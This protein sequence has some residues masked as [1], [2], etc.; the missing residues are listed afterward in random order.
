MKTNAQIILQVISISFLLLL[1]C[2]CCFAGSAD[3]LTT[4]GEWAVST[5]NPMLGMS[6]KARLVVSE[7]ADNSGSRMAVTYVELQNPNNAINVL[8][9]Y[10]NGSL[11]ELS[12]ELLDSR[13]KAV[14]SQMSGPYNG[15][16]PEPCW[17]ALPID[18]TVRFHPSFYR[19]PAASKGEL[20]ID[21]GHNQW[22][23]WVIPRDDTNDYYLSG[24]LSLTVPEGEAPPPWRMKTGN[25]SVVTN[26]VPYDV[27]HA[28]LKLP[29]VKISAKYLSGK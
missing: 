21:A 22:R 7:T 14:P 5:N 8:Y 16:M 18:S 13:G 9:V 15:P 12:C 20:Y 19:A 4:F 17:L 2:Q 26:P 3:E 11:P 24:T 28:A 29:P 27:C 10:Y 6:L 25:A 23:H 1:V